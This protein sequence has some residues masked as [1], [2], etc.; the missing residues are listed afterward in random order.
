MREEVEALKRTVDALPAAFDE[1]NDALATLQQ[2][3]VRRHNETQAQL[4]SLSPT[5]RLGVA[6]LA[7]ILARARD[8]VQAAYERLELAKATLGCILT[9]VE[10]DAKAV[11]DAPE[12]ESTT[13]G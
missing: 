8:R 7:N 1:F 6:P 3:L 13:D 10:R 11:I 12:P 4:D 9:S 2:A 5:E